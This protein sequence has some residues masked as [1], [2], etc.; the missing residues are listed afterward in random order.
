MTRSWRSHRDRDENKRRATDNGAGATL[1]RSEIRADESRLDARPAARLA[2]GGV[3]ERK[4]VLHTTNAPKNELHSTLVF[5]RGGQHREEEGVI[6][7]CLW[8]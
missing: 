1:S 5:L 6:Q 2:V 4:S 3:E 7:S 8:G